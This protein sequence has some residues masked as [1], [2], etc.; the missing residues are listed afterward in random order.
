MTKTILQID[1]SAR[2]AGSTTRDLTKRIA[3][4]L[5]GTVVHRDLSN[6][7]PQINEDWVNANFTAADDRTA[8]QIATL[9]L[10]NTL[11]SELQAADV[12][13]IGVPMYNFGIPAALKAWIDQV[14]RA[15]VTFSYTENGPVGL[16]NGK[17]AILALAT[18]GTKLNSEIDF[19][20]N[21][22]KHVLGFLGIH[23]VEVVSA[24][25]QMV[26]AEQAHSK[27]EQ[28]IQSLAA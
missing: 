9:A 25:Q 7:V 8:E 4:K 23:D 18:G 10:S 17:R 11:V 19:A 13:V 28:S 12:V 15:G 2:K 3:E 5:G 27:A 24:D 1:A 26:D 21:Y 20:T 16:L 14:A 22:M 6:P